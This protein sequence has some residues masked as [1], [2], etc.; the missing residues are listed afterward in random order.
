MTS[1]PLT[2]ASIAAIALSAGGVFA[3]SY[4]PNTQ[5][6]RVEM[7]THIARPAYL[8]PITDPLFGTKVT[9]ISDQSALNSTEPRLAHAYAK[10]QPT[11]A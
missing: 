11:A 8:L 7:P 3:Q 5:L 10:N 6:T 1:E 2:L 9:R 4:P